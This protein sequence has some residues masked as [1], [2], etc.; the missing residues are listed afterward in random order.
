MRNPALAHT[1]FGVETVSILDREALENLARWLCQENEYHDRL[2]SYGREKSKKERDSGYDLFEAEQNLNG[3]YC[4]KCRNFA[5]E[6]LSEF[7]LKVK[8]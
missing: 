2:E 3:G 5:G 8:P 6:L 7:D 4:N 1:S